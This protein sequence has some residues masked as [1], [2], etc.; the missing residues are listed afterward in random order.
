MEGQRWLE[1]VLSHGGRQERRVRALRGLAI[2]LLERGEP[3]RAETLAAEA[4]ELAT[5]SG[6]EHQA[7]RAAGLLADVAAN[8]GDMDTARERYEQ[9]A[10]MARRAG[11]DREAA[12]N[13]YNLG[14]VARVQ[15]DFDRADAF[16]EETHR[17][18]TEL[19]DRVGQ[20]GTLLG[21]A[22]TA[23]LRGD[24]SR[25]PERMVQALE[26]MLDVGYPGG[27]VDC[28]NLIGGFAADNGDPARAARVWGAAAALDEQMG[29]Q[30]H[31]ADAAGYNEA[32]AAA[33][34]A[35]GAETFDRLWAEGKALTVEEAAEYALAGLQAGLPQ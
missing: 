14:H 7:A 10:E 23:Q 32:I 25:M 29:R 15:G 26:L 35:C 18:F 3:D 27:I 33:R 1:E 9:A 17:M 6:N 21:L 28:F 30:T 16:F 8:R 12:V 22:E 13:L 2:L 24:R 31:P 20:G 11:D 4:L 19:D 34:S 5:E